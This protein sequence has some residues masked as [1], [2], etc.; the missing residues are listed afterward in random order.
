MDEKTAHPRRDSSNVERN[1]TNAEFLHDKDILGENEHAQEDAMHFGHLSDEEL[2][3][4]KKL[5]RKID[6][7][8]MPVVVLVISNL[9]TTQGRKCAY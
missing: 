9:S 7:T 4:E 3:L 6:S 8:I 2:V 1:I 5:R